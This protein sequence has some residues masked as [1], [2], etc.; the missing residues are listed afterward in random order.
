MAF[1]IEQGDSIWVQGETAAT[2]GPFPLLGG[3]YGI[4][5]VQV[6]AG[7]VVVNRLGPDASNTNVPV[8]T[9]LAAAGNSY[10]AIG[11]PAGQYN[12]VVSG[13]AT[14]SVSVSPVAE[15]RT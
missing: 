13:A 8:V 3:V 4:T 6:G 9:A 14:G 7:G 12:V 5:M 15:N 1:A 11:L 2:Y 10:T